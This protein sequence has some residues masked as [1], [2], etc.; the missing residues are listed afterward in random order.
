MSTAVSNADRSNASLSLTDSRTRLSRF[1]EKIINGVITASGMTSIVFV[2]LI[3]LFIFKEAFPLLSTYPAA[4]FF[5][6]REWAPTTEGVGGLPDYGLVPLLLSSVLVTLGA[7]ALAV[8]LGVA[9]AVYIAEVAPP[10]F[11]PTLKAL[12]ELL[13]AVPSVVLGF[14]GMMVLGPYLQARFGFATG[15][16]LLTGSITLAL[17]AVP[18]IATISEDALAAVPRDI[19]EASLGL[20]ATHWQTVRNVIFP[21]AASGVV[22]AVMLGVGR[23]IGETMVV[24]MVTGNG[25]GIN[26]LQLM[27]VMPGTNNPLTAFQNVFGAYAEVCRTL[28]ATVASEMGEVVPGQSHYHALFMLG[29][30]LFVITF[31]INFTADFALKRTRDVRSGSGGASAFLSFLAVLGGVLGIGVTIAL[32]GMAGD[33]AGGLGIGLLVATL[34]LLVFLIR[35][36]ITYRRPIDY[37]MY[38]CLGLG[39]LAAL[40]PTLFLFGNILIGGFRQLTPGFLTQAPSD[41]GTAG[42]IGPAILGTLGLMFGTILLALPLGICAA[43][44]LSE[45]AKKGPLVGAIRMAIVNLAGVPSIV[46]GLFGLIVFKTF[47]GGWL[48]YFARNSTPVWQNRTLLWGAATLAIL[49]LPIV[50]TTTEEALLSVPAS[51]REGSVGLGATRWQTIRRVVLPAAIPG[52]LTGAIL[53]I[54]RSAG[55]TAPILFTAAVTFT[56]DVRLPSP[57]APVLALPYHLY[58][59]VTQA[60]QAS[61]GLKYGIALVLLGLVFTV[62]ITAILLRTRLRR[63]RRW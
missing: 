38:A 47:L 43:I 62:N 30:V 7:V 29:V 27:G 40:L 26:L 28:T 10:R 59:V 60:T 5:F 35:P 3:F 61:D 8:P 21:A 34:A 44:Y 20:G 12:I 54:G 55:E 16:T 15:D 19:R 17:M 32:V 52:I 51:F 31:L 9:T 56:T 49:V 2:A 39:L 11:R 23:A 63:A 46:H 1:R 57:D 42:G 48:D 25:V 53:A 4:R 13:A 18:T 50:I 6:G 58:Y 41:G 14:F 37:A 24:L 33:A 36:T 22:A 45:F